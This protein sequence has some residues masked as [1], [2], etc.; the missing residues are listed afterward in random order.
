MTPDADETAVSGS[1]ER[2]DD[3]RQSGAVEVPLIVGVAAGTTTGFI[4]GVA[5]TISTLPNPK[6]RRDLP[7]VDDDVL[8]EDAMSAALAE[9]KES[10]KPFTKDQLTK[11]YWEKVDAAHG[12]ISNSDEAVRQSNA[13][14]VQDNIKA[15][16]AHVLPTTA[17][18]TGLGAAVGLVAAALWNR[19]VK[20]AKERNADTSHERE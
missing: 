17:I 16:N 14:T 4:T 2:S 7:Y 8:H 15:I 19:R 12:A 18:S 10:G 1:V 5:T 6:P 11:L 20:K 9:L 13:Q 3:K